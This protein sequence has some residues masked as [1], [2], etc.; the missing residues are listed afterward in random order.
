MTVMKDAALKKTHLAPVKNEIRLLIV[1]DEAL[2]RKGLVSLFQLQK[3][4]KVVGEAQ[5]APEAVD[6]ARELRPDVIL[7]D[8]Q[9]P[10]CSGLQAVPLIREAYSDANIIILALSD[11]ENN[12]FA[13]MRAGAKGYLYKNIDPEKLYKC[14]S[15][16]HQGEVV[17][18]RQMASKLFTSPF[19]PST[20]PA[21][22]HGPL[23][24]REKEILNCLGQGA[25]NKEIGA[26]L[27]ISEHTV[28]I[29]LRHIL[30]KLRLNNRVQ[31]A[32]FALKENPQLHEGPGRMAAPD[33]NT[34]SSLSLY[35]KA[36]PT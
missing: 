9:M 1:D 32:I 19:S 21:S 33:R 22:N 20:S 11:E 24:P 30:K 29:H 34:S 2:T 6:K 26:T 28:K 36:A 7:M 4:M 13:T 25:S 18:P 16:V 31:A 17:L 10:G 23:T 27:G 5:D 12:I 3:G 15:L 35:P 14:I 8:S